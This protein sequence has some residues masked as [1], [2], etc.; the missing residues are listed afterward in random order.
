MDGDQKNKQFLNFLQEE[1]AI[2][3]ASISVARKHSEAN[4]GPLPMILWQFGMISLNQL[5]QI[6]DW[7]ESYNHSTLCYNKSAS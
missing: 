4:C 1:L 3:A 5:Q 7:L 2:S 6:F